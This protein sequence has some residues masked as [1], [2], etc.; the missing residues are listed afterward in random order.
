MPRQHHRQTDKKIH[1][2]NILETR[3]YYPNSSFGLSK[4]GYFAQSYIYLSRDISFPPLFPVFN[5][6]SSQLS[7]DSSKR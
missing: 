3:W 5:T 4:H 6:G 7:L 2:I 1:L